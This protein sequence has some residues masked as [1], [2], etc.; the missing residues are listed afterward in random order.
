M[1]EQQPPAIPTLEEIEDPVLTRELIDALNRG[2]WGKLP[3]KEEREALGRLTDTT[4]PTVRRWFS[5]GGALVPSIVI[6]VR[7]SDL[8]PD[9]AARVEVA[10]RLAGEAAIFDLLVKPAQE[11][12]DA[13][14][15]G[16]TERTMKF[17]NSPRVETLRE[18]IL[19][20]E[21]IK[22]KDF[23][24][25]I[26]ENWIAIKIRRN[27]AGGYYL[28][29]RYMSGAI[30]PQGWPYKKEPPPMP[31]RRKKLKRTKEEIRRGR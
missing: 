11:G 17:E 24:W 4:Q 26:S 21:R 23:D 31:S 1:S 19:L 8:Y 7:P 30:S 2:V 29:I 14:W 25:Y 3:G 12:H 20:I 16:G 10:L 15:E 27:P 6:G 5:K 9:D 22:A 13:E 18:A 28:E